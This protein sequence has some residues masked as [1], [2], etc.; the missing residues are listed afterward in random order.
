[1]KGKAAG[2][3][4]KS[5]RF[6]SQNNNY[7][8]SCRLSFQKQRLRVTKSSDCDEQ[9]FV[10]GGRNFIHDGPNYVRL[11][12]MFVHHEPNYVRHEP[13]FICHEPMFVRDEQTL[14]AVISRRSCAGRAA[15]IEL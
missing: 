7:F 1:M 3:L 2:S 9:N 8:S 6:S 12:P 5:Q 13:M 4:I 15:R 11:E 14:A 10:C